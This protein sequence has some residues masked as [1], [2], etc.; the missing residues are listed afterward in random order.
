M[1]RIGIDSKGA[2]EGGRKVASAMG[3]V[4]TAATSAVKPLL[5]VGAAIA[6]LAGI[7]FTISRVIGVLSEFDDALVEIQ[8]STNRSSE[9]SRE[10]YHQFVALSTV[11][12]RATKDMVELASVAYQL[13][14]KSNQDIARFVETALKISATTDIKSAGGIR[15]LGRFLQVSGNSGKDVEALGA[16]IN[17]LSDEF[18]ATGGEIVGTGRVILQLSSQLGVTE[19]QAIA[20]SAALASFGSDSSAAGVAV[21]RLFLR[22]QDAVKSGGDLLDVVAAIA[23]KT[24]GDFKKAFEVDA[25]G[26][27]Q[28]LLRGLNALSRDREG[29]QNAL[30]ILNIDDPR[31][32]RSVRPLIANY[33]VLGKALAITAD[34]TGNLANLNE[35]AER[36]NSSLSSE[37]TRLGNAFHAMLEASTPIL[38]F[39]KDS[40]AYFRVLVTTIVGLPTEVTASQRA[41]AE[42]MRAIA[43]Y[44]YVGTDVVYGRVKA[45]VKTLYL[46]LTEGAK[47]MVE[48]VKTLFNVTIGLFNAFFPQL[49]L[50]IRSIWENS[51]DLL[52]GLVGLVVGSVKAILFAVT[53]TA[54]KIINLLAT[55]SRLSYDPRAILTAGQQITELL[56]PVSLGMNIGKILAEE[57][58]Y[59]WTGALKTNAKIIASVGSDVFGGADLFGV[60]GFESVFDEFDR[61]LKERQAETAGFLGYKPSNEFVGPPTP[62]RL[63]SANSVADLAGLKDRIF[64]LTKLGEAQRQ[65]NKAIA[66]MDKEREAVVRYGANVEG[67]S[68]ELERQ[69]MLVDANKE[70]EAAFGTGTDA[71]KNAV[72]RYA[73]A[74]DKLGQ[75]RRQ[76]DL[77]VTMRGLR[78]QI[79]ALQLAGDESKNYISIL[80]F[81]R[82]AT[83]AFGDDVDAASNAIDDY[84]K[85][86]KEL[87][88]SADLKQH[89][90]SLGDIL[91]SPFEKAAFEADNFQDAVKQMLTDISREMFRFSVIAPLSKFFTSVLAGAA[92]AYGGGMSGGTAPGTPGFVGPPAPGSAFGNLFGNGRLQPFAGGGLFSGPMQFPM[93]DGRRGLA[94]ENGLEV[95]MPAKRMADGSIGV[96]G[97]GGGNTVIQNITTP[98][99]GG[100]RRSSYQIARDAK[101]ALK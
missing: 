74:F 18:G 3:Q 12:P 23:G 50:F 40:I 73:A 71:A 67:L 76:S 44:I 37:I 48:I 90:E 82:E 95:L 83:L 69:K 58:T 14:N 57:M 5:A 94:G 16:A 75:A 51:T 35:E 29:L 79:A 8:N 30:E 15:D 1:I 84:R 20:L 22:M 55:M 59:S 66:D 17:S 99:I 87:D 56:D 70:A 62:D 19:D 43:D 39:L 28:A 63:G 98:D 4:G 7:G 42:T 24:S 78:D 13:G 6:A 61:K 46:L 60:F 10:L 47:G 45:I 36:A 97:N 85:S 21:G 89:F 11:V 41:I 92:G 54:Q 101:R 65:F 81:S 88:R 34:R 9:E 49:S 93:A 52:N 25:V 91:A 26:S 27:M 32:Q 80:E 68:I 77:S 53:D 86:L 38:D 31:M 33:E 64:A 96:R 100:F 72:L 2:E